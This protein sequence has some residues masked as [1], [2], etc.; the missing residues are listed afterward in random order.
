MGWAVGWL[1]GRQL[2]G[3]WARMV[4]PG[5]GL[6]WWGRAG[7]RMRR[8]RCVCRRIHWWPS[9]SLW[10]VMSLMCFVE[11]AVFFVVFVIFLSYSLG[12]PYL[13]GCFVIS[14][15]V[16]SYP[17]AIFYAFGGFSILI[18]LK[19]QGRTNYFSRFLKNESIFYVVFSY[20]P[21]FCKI[22]PDSKGLNAIRT[23][24]MSFSPQN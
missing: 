24:S 23:L 9:Y 7:L 17:L 20:S 16:S 13:F 8:A 5:C 6:G 15:R 11:F 1:W 12:V 19:I 2:A 14:V 10:F 3:P 4:G 18:K 22:G 21:I